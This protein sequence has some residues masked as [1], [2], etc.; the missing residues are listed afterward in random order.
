[1][2]A[3]FPATEQEVPENQWGYGKRLR[4]VRNTFGQ[5][6]PGR[7]PSS[8]RVLDVG[9]GNGSFLA[10]PLAHG[11][12][13]ITGVDPH[14]PSIEHAVHLAHHIP[15][16]QF[17]CG[18]VETI[19]AGTF[20]AVILSEVLEHVT[21]PRALLSASTR[22]LHENG[23]AIV[24]VPNGFGE[25]EIDSWIYRKLRLQRLVDVLA[26]P[27]TEFVSATDNQGNGHVQLFTLRCLQRLFAQCS[28]R[29]FR[30]EAASLLSG[31]IIGVTLAR[32]PRFIRWNARITDKLPLSLASGWYFGLKRDAAIASQ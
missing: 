11:G 13:R 30:Q 3:F 25:F 4:F 23:I 7:P 20:D 9:C 18:R 6:F 15:N 2:T 22:C 21:H 8:L 12:F 5:A 26:E 17:V 27:P 10:L 14:A 31:P 16:A 28:L 32:Y 19:A 24:T 1:M 29:I